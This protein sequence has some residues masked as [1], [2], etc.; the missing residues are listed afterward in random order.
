V[1]RSRLLFL[2]PLTALAACQPPEAPPRLTPLEQ[3]TGKQAVATPRVNGKLGTPNA[4]PRPQVSFGALPAPPQAPSAMG[5]FQGGG[6]TSL[7]FADTDIRQ[8]VAQILG[9][10]LRVNYAIDPSVH[11]TATFHTSHPLSRSELVPV[12]KTLLSQNNAALIVDNGI[13]RVVSASGPA[14]LPQEGAAGFAIPLHY[15]SAEELA[16]VLQPFVGSGGKLVADPGRNAVLIS[17]EP[18]ARDALVRLVRSFDVDVLADQSYALLPVQAGSAKDFASTLQ[19][20][21]RSQSGGPLSG[22]VKVIPMERAS[23]VLVVASQP[24]YLED[25]RRVYSLVLRAQ[26]TTLRSWHVYYLQNSHASDIAYLLQ[27]AFTPNEVTEQPSQAATIAASGAGQGGGASFNSGGSGLGGGT[28][29]GGGS[30]GL[31]GGGSGGLGSNSGNGLGGG[32]GG[33]LGSAGGSG[34]GQYA[35]GGGGGSMASANPLLGGLD[36]SGGGAGGGNPNSMRIISNP[37]NNAVLIY[38]TAQ[39]EN[40]VEAML[41]KIDILPLQVRIDATIAEVQLNDELK[42]GTQFFFKEGSLNETLANVSNFA[43]GSPAFLVNVTAKGVNATLSS[44][45][46]VTKVNVLS[47]PEV[48]VL[49]NQPAQLMVGD[50]VPYLTQ[51]SQSTVANS[52]VINS[53]DY[54]QTGVIMK[55]TPRVNSGGLVTLDIT[56]EVSSINTAAPTYQGISSPTFSDRSIQSRVVVQDGQTVGLAG[57]ISDT[58]Q[59]GNQGIPFLKDVPVLNVFAGAQ[60]NQHTRTEL[61]VLLTPHVVHDQRDAAAL[62]EDLRS[63][64]S[65]AALV[66]QEAAMTQL[67]GSFD[68]GRRGRRQLGLEP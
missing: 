58:Q 4:L 64:L 16:K 22:V 42:Y 61:L 26:Q 40:T 2:M 13:Y 46:A 52:S 35:G 23:A 12:L 31:G 66:P 50:L 59:R 51:S 24:R 6:D 53:I 21:F 17:G 8:V 27:R 45:Q 20:A 9:E 37:Q 18:A 55:V 36:A 41:H 14:L 65:N 7:D 63:E 48:L 33:G 15:V 32:L 44:L 43:P 39:E 56:Q 28:S 34:L 30:G 11:G 49:D 29:S 54:R 38:A 19:D 25:A 62:T 3:P 1:T 68:P 5:A 67:S 47:S 60:N 57:L 10:V